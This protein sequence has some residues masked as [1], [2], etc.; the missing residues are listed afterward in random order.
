VDRAIADD[1]D[2]AKLFND[3]SEGLEPSQNTETPV[4]YARILVNGSSDA[5][6]PTQWLAVAQRL[7]GYISGKPATFTEAADL[8]KDVTPGKA[9]ANDI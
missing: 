3:N 5:L 7:Q 4:A 6:T 9:T 1:P 8:Y 2:V